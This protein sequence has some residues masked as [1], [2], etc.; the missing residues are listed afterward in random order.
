ML[1]ATS[2]LIILKIVDQVFIIRVI[3]SADNET[4][5]VNQW[6]SKDVRGPWTT[7]SPGPLPIHHNLIPLT[8]PSHTPY[9]DFAHVYLYYMILNRVILQSG[10]IICLI[11]GE[12]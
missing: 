9:S 3:S 7:D 10:Y 1:K 12:K 2:L 11:F 6:R 4:T 5:T 8:P